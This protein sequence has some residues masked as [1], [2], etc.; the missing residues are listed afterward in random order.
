[1]FCQVKGSTR[2][3][4]EHCISR[5]I[6]LYDTKINFTLFT[7][8]RNYKSIKDLSTFI[9]SAVSNFCFISFEMFLH[10]YIKRAFPENKLDENMQIPIFDKKMSFTYLNCRYYQLTTPTILNSSIEKC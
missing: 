3:A 1:M 9:E 6:L 5:Q 8:T 2:Y 7:V 10:A 4:S